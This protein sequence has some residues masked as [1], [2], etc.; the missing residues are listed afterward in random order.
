MKMQIYIQLATL[1]L[2]GLSFISNEVI[3]TYIPFIISLITLIFVA[4]IIIRREYQE[5]RLTSTNI[6]IFL[7]VLLNIIFLFDFV[8]FTRSLSQ[9]IFYIQCFVLF[10]TIQQF[11]TEKYILIV[12]KA[13]VILTT[14]FGIFSFTNFIEIGLLSNLR[15]SGIV[16]SSDIYA[17]FLIIPFLLSIYFIYTETVIWQK[18]LWYFCSAI[19]LTSLFL[20]FSIHTWIILILLLLYFYRKQIKEPNAIIKPI[21]F[22]ATISF[23]VFCTVWYMAKQTMLH[24]DS[25]AIEQAVRYEENNPKV[26]F[27]SSR[28]DYFSD[29]L[30][31]ASYHPIIGYGA[32][33]YTD[34]LRMYKPYY[35]TGYIADPHNWFL[36]ILVENGLLVAIVFVVFVLL[37][38][39]EIKLRLK[40]ANNLA[41]IV[42]VGLLASVLNGLMSPDWSMNQVFLIWIIFASLLY[43]YLAKINDVNQVY[44]IIPKWFIYVLLFVVIISTIISTQFLRADIARIEGDRY[45]INKNNDGALMSYFRSASLNPQEPSTWYKIWQV[46]YSMNKLEPAKNS[47][48][49]AIE[50]YEQNVTYM[51]ALDKTKKA[52]YGL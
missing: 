52:L 10:I 28:L 42:F 18:R 41:N 16:G 21:L 3:Q 49:K 19:I 9:I 45:Y 26:N 22:V 20:T 25:V 17:G 11:S 14:V 29:A 34:V 8:Y 1:V 36:K 44:R 51:S 6:T 23:L 37:Y 33:L 27:F 13:F 7:F 15:L 48:E 4:L 43:G 35:A 5:I 31:V 32:G 50:L 39:I 30:M 38:F 46:Y 24:R 12:S 2:V 47:I 40:N